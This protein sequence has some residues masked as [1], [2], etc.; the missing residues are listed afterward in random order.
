MSRSSI[1][2]E[3]NG[4]NNNNDGDEHEEGDVKD[5]GEGQETE[6]VVEGGEIDIVGEKQGGPGS[7]GEDR[8]G[9]GS[10]REDR[11]GPGSDGEEH[12]GPGSE[13]EER[14]GPG[15]LSLTPDIV[16]G[17]GDEEE[18]DSPRTPG[19]IVT[20][21]RLPDMLDHTPHSQGE[22]DR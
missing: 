19:G 1:E 7:E 22:P 20:I 5:Q 17:R 15:S 9:P 14:G 3:E 13:G 21:S 18:E 16:K 2:K 8:G 12:G 11:G 6:Q 10:E 4:S